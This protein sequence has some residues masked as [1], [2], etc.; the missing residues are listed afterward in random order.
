M[1][2]SRKGRTSRF[3]A[4]AKQGRGREARPLITRV[5]IEDHALCEAK[6]VSERATL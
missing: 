3:H 5:A 4:L 6:D 2:F 1:P